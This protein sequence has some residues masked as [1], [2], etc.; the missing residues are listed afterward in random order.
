MSGSRATVH[1]RRNIDTFVLL[2]GVRETLYVRD[3]KREYSVSPNDYLILASNRE[4]MGTRKANAGLSYYWC[5]FYISG[6]Y[7]LFDLD[8][9]EM[10]KFGEEE[11]YQIPMHGHVKSGEKMH[12]LFRQLIDASRSASPYAEDICCGFLDVIL[13]KLVAEA[14]HTGAVR[15]W[16]EATVANIVEWIKIN[17]PEIESVKD[18]A[19]HFGYNSEYLATMVKRVTGKTPVD[20]VNDCRI[21][22][23]CDLLHTTRDTLSVIAAQSGFSDEKYFSRVFKKKCGISPGQYRKAYQR[24]H[25]NH[26]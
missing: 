15:E 2:Y 22:L 12:L 7:S 14:N 26:K 8:G 10:I 13:C 20:I 3:G 25:I 21:N 11:H 1:P 5:H 9:K 18:V 24:K 6:E 16:R 23:A 19:R 4:H 17:A